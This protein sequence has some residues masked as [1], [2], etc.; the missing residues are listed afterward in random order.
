M[1]YQVLARKWRPNQFSDVLGQ[2]H[3]LMALSNAL[4]QQRL[5]HA[6]LLSGTRGVGKTTIARIFAKG[7]NCEQGIVATPCGTCATCQEIAR[8]SFVDLLEIDAASRTK[9]EDTRELLDNVQYKPARGRFKVYL[10]DEVHMLS[11]HSFN[12]LLKT[13]EEPPEHVKFILATTD[14]QKL[15]VTVLSRCLQLHLKHLDVLQIE[16]KLAHILTQESLAFDAP[17][18][19]LLAKAAN[20]SMR[21]ALSLTDQAIAQGG[22]S[23]RESGVASM[24]GILDSDFVQRLLEAVA[25]DSAPLLMQ[26]V[27]E[28][29]NSGVEW[30]RLLSD[31]AAQLHQLAVAQLLGVDPA[32][33]PSAP[34]IARLSGKF[35][36]QEVQLFYQIVLQ[37]RQDLPFAPDGRSGVEM[38]LLRMLAFKPDEVT[39][40]SL[41]PLGADSAISS[42]SISVAA[43]SCATVKNLT[44][45]KAQLQEQ[46][47]EPQKPAALDVKQGAAKQAAFVPVSDLVTPAA[48]KK[49]ANNDSQPL[50]SAST[51]THAPKVMA[52]V[53]MREQVAPVITDSCASVASSTPTSPPELPPLITPTAEQELAPQNKPFLPKEQ[54]PLAPPSKEEQTTLVAQSE[55]QML[56]DDAIEGLLS[57][58]KKLQQLRAALV[59]QGA[60]PLE[61]RSQP[62]KAPS[63][64]KVQPQVK[65]SLQPAALSQEHTHS[66]LSKG[67]AQEP[68]NAQAGFDPAALQA[69]ADYDS[70]DNELESADH[71]FEQEPLKIS[72]TIQERVFNTA[73]NRDAIEEKNTQEK[74][75]SENKS[76]AANTNDGAPASFSK[77]LNHID[78]DQLA[79]KLQTRSTA[80]VTDAPAYEEQEES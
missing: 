24:L 58:R 75:P 33:D 45:L 41:A 31:M 3:V 39:P 37:G 60:E 15:P 36:A 13:L 69:Y 27:Q 43:P 42:S 74:K 21:D 54:T 55:S 66:P 28:L 17:A 50:A 65:A 8:G 78:T 34:K 5:H 80:M 6:Y 53:D 56:T 63:Q 29:A 19:K 49:I 44:A 25:A 20:G 38:T 73:V 30:D 40:I 57:A 67:L 51:S 59:Q 46:K 1:S 23:V 14:P 16:N 32:S 48:E 35:S 70:A 18:L 64:V 7:L 77:P 47:Q 71:Y 62:K 76:A 79:P 52:Q 26:T 10:I 61:P 4:S 68:E 72:D 12:A 2:E 9:V 22:G 11:R